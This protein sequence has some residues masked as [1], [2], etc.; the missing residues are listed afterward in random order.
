MPL[1]EIA[2]REVHAELIWSYVPVDFDLVGAP[3]KVQ[4]AIEA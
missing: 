3:N 2:K 1:P 4:F